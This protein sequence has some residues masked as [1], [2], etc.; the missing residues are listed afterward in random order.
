MICEQVSPTPYIPFSSIFSLMRDVFMYVDET[1][2][3]G[4]TGANGSSHY[5]GIGS[6]SFAGPHAEP[7]WQLKHLRFLLQGRGIE[8]RTGFHAKND[9]AR[10]RS[11]VYQAIAVGKPRFDFTMLEKRR[12]KDDVLRK[13]EVYFY[14]LA[15]YLH[16]KEIVRRVS[17]PG[18]T[19]FV[20][21]ATLGT[22]RRRSKL[23]A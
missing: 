11:D 22:A 14:R 9:S 20:A 1:G 4:L 16:F 19:V 17:R 12:A 18:D 3:L 23:R 10:T 21:V 7:I 8:V 15:W 5:F 6:A 2:D 13:G